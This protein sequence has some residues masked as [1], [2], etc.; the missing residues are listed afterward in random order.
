M[1]ESVRQGLLPGDVAV[2]NDDLSFGPLD[3]E[4]RTSFWQMLHPLFALDGA[5]DRSWDRL[6]QLATRREVVLW[7]GANPG[8]IVLLNAACDGLSDAPDAI[9]HVDVSSARSGAH[10]VAELRPVF[11]ASLFPEYSRQLR[12]TEIR[13]RAA[14]Y[15]RMATFS[16]SLRRYELGE[17]VEAPVDVYDP[18]LLQAMDS[19]WQPAA[20]VIGSAMARCDPHNRMGDVFFTWRLDVLA[21]NG[22]VERAFDGPIRH[23]SIRPSALAG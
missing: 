21:A 22:A 4:Q 14:E 10:F 7:G 20:Q 11:A 18:W 3:P 23:T 5:P 6:R 8:D 17:V 19:D 16:G 12:P 1:R 15:R 13:D 9:W 2:L